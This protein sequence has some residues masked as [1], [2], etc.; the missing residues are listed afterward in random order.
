MRIKTKE[1]KYI[2]LHCSK[3]QSSYPSKLDRRNGIL[4]CVNCGKYT[5]QVIEGD[6]Y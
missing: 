4:R 1:I 6:K 5:G 2:G 3:C